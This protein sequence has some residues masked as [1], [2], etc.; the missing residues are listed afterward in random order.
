MRIKIVLYWIK[1]RS[2]KN[3]LGEG[4]VNVGQVW[5]LEVVKVLK[6]RRV[7]SLNRVKIVWLS[8]I[9]KIQSKMILIEQIW[10]SWLWCGWCWRDRNGI[11]HRQR[12]RRRHRV[13][14][15]H[16]KEWHPIAID[17]TW[18]PACCIVGPLANHR[19][20]HHL[21]WKPS[22]GI[23]YAW[24]CIW[25]PRRHIWDPRDGVWI[26]CCSKSIPIYFPWPMLPGVF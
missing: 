25:N 15:G 21:Q 13:L 6:V 23:W 3:L 2:D 17:S 19:I 18:V 9:T 5:I 22:C 11:L 14:Y 26:R 8:E 4:S 7:V 12:R 1:S 24:N 16:G 20:P 10:W